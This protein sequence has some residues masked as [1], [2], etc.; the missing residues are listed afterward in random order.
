MQA[1]IFCVEKH[2][3]KAKV[4][5]DEARAGYAGRVGMALGELAAAEEEAK[6]GY[7]VLAQELRRI[8]KEM[9]TERKDYQA[10]WED[11]LAG[12]EVLVAVADPATRKMPESERLPV[13]ETTTAPPSSSSTTP[14]KQ[15]NMSE[16]PAAGVPMVDGKPLVTPITTGAPAVRKQPVT[17][18]PITG[19]VSKNPPAE[20]GCTSCAIASELKANGTLD[21]VRAENIADHT[22][23][24]PARRVVILTSLGD[25]NPAY[26]LVTCILDQARALHLAG[27][28]VSV[29]VNKGCNRTQLPPLPPEIEIRDVMPAHSLKEDVVHE[30]TYTDTLTALVTHLRYFGSAAVITHDFVFQS[31]FVTYAKVMHEISKQLGAQFRFYHVMHS[32]VGSPPRD[33]EIRKLR[34][35]IPTGHQMLALSEADLPY[36][37]KYYGATMDRF[38]VVPNIRDPRLLLN[39]SA[40]ACEIVDKTQLHLASIAQVY[41]LS[42]PRMSA[43][44]LQH[45]IRL[46]A[47]LQQE[48]D[49]SAQLRLVVV[50]AHANGIEGKKQK[51]SMQALAVAE[52]LH[53]GVLWFSSDIVPKKAASGLSANDVQGLMRLANLFAF[54]SVSEAGSLVLQ[55]ATLAGNLV[56]LNASLPCLLEQYRGAHVLAHPWGSSKRETPDPSEGLG[57]LVNT[58]WQRVLENSKVSRAPWR[59]NSAE[60]LGYR[61]NEVLVIPPLPA[62][63]TKT[64]EQLKAE[65]QA[66]VRT[67]ARPRTPT[68]P[69]AKPTA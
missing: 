12:I 44:G 52:G 29:F 57:G 61:L 35:T 60:V 30:K 21:R 58:I 31:W 17:I 46:F 27:K 39:L 28:R 48:T 41:P 14:P 49:S 64:L 45:V 3:A 19:T 13:P 5:H 65:Q 20:P 40:E 51:A 43:K 63:A 67:T 38:Y 56:V 4:Y 37:T 7:P 33:P 42:A 11:L 18:A 8:R 69:A 36:L 15:R 68:P 59:L 32:S 53:D 22:A 54:P 6:D 25:F 62:A 16:V 34:A 2:V 55:E 24:L 23:G 47:K 9:E 1:C 10:P 26:S 66:L 50:D